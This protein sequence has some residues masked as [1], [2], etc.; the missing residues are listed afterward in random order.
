MKRHP[1]IIV[2]S[3]TFNYV[4]N[5]N[6]RNVASQ[7]EQS[8]IGNTNEH[9]NEYPCHVPKILFQT[10]L[11]EHRTI[12]SHAT[13]NYKTYMS[14]PKFFIFGKNTLQVVAIAKF[15]NT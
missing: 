1:L 5:K 10:N 13:P 2:V 11:R 15:A 14:T 12:E 8:I 4:Q 6:I 9:N 7:L 3:C